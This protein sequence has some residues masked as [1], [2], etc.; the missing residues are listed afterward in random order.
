MAEDVEL[1]EGVSIAMLTVLQTLTPTERAVHARAW[2]EVDDALSLLIE[3]ARPLIFAGDFNEQEPSRFLPQSI[4]RGLCF[5]P[6]GATT[7]K[8]Y[9]RDYIGFL[10]LGLDQVKVVPSPS[11]HWLVRAELRDALPVPDLSGPRLL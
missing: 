3:D 8:G 4:Q 9:V 10:H 11:D 2:E 1:A 6:T 5:A 7:A